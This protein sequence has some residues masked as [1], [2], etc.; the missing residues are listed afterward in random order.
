MVVAEV[1]AKKGRITGGRASV[2]I[3][4]SEAVGKKP[5]HANAPVKW[6]REKARDENRVTSLC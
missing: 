3:A 4:T 2:P 6:I 5:R 1:P